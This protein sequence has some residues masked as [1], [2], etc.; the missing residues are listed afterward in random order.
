MYVVFNHNI[1]TGFYLK[2]WCAYMYIL[3]FGTSNLIIKILK[4]KK[5][6]SLQYKIIFIEHSRSPPVAVCALSLE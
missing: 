2:G 5:Q 3:L 6:P 4:Y 1:K